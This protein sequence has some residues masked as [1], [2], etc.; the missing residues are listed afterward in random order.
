MTNSANPY[1]SH[2]PNRYL[3]SV[4]HDSVVVAAFGGKHSRTAAL[5]SQHRDGLFVATVVRH[6]G[7]SVVRGST[8]ATGFKALRSLL[9]VAR[10]KDIVITSDGPRG[11]RRT[12]SR[13]IVYLSSRSGNAIVP[14]AFA[15]SRC[16]RI[17]G[18]WTDLVIPRP[19]SRVI[20]LAGDPI[21]VP[22]ALSPRQLSQYVLQLQSEMDRLDRVASDFL[23]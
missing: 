1:L 8:G 7:V 3:F 21:H 4:W 16:W 22:P 6:A 14:T 23:A 10:E 17:H 5:T 11:P 2:G 12:V 18:S 20:L 19:F 15:C 9:T 13:G